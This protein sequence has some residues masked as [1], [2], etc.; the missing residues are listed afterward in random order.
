MN[1][2]MLDSGDPYILG[3]RTPHSHSRMQYRIDSLETIV[4]ALNTELRTARGELSAIARMIPP[5]Y[6][7]AAPLLERVASIIAGCY[8]G[9]EP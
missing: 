4:A 8:A 6:F 5:T 3:Y 9:G 1:P 7:P 2:S